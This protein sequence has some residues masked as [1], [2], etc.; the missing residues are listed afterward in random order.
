MRLSWRYSKSINTA[1]RG[2]S[3]STFLS[4]FPI[5]EAPSAYNPSPGGFWAHVARLSPLD[6]GF[7][8]VLLLFVRLVD[9]Q[10]FFALQLL[11]RR[12]AV[13]F[14]LGQTDVGTKE[15]RKGGEKEGLEGLHGFRFLRFNGLSSVGSSIVQPGCQ[16]KVLGEGCQGDA[17]V[18]TKVGFTMNRLKRC[19]A[20]SNIHAKVELACASAAFQRGVH[21]PT[22][23]PFLQ[24]RGLPFRRR[25]WS[26]TGR[27]D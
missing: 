12:V 6:V 9:A 5:K 22:H 15:H 18:D 16:P 25:W 4:S 11:F 20:L 1:L 13:T 21:S 17:Q 24:R 14:V 7:V 23:A 8:V 27:V 2:S 26:T 19:G 10:S 3:S